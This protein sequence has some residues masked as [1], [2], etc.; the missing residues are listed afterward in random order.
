MD[1]FFELPWRQ[2]PALALTLVGAALAFRG[3]RGMPNPTRQQVDVMAW[4]RGFRRA[5]TGL[6]LALA[7]LAWLYQL[8]WLLAIALGV[9][10]QELRESTHYIDTLRRAT[11]RRKSHAN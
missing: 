5:V 2:G 10:L 1:A 4:L 8:P 6:A 7:G 11:P 9:G 3:L